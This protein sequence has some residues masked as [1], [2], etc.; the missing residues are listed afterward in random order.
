MTLNEGSHYPELVERIE[1]RVS[2]LLEQS[3]PL[4]RRHRVAVPEPVCLFD[5][6]GRCAG[7]ARA[8]PGMPPQLRFN[9]AMAAVQP[10]RYLDETVPHEVAHLVAAACFG[11][12]I[13]PH[14]EHWR[15]VMRHFGIRDPRRCHD[16]EVVESQVRRQRRWTYDCGC[17][18]HE[19]TTTRH[20]RVRAGRA[21]YVC[22]DCGLTLQ[23]R[24]RENLPEL[25]AGHSGEQ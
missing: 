4:C 3:A 10:R 25:L 1:Q 9:L 2:M 15:S 23:P 13:P 19:L 16:Y 12:N 6:R 5:L 11:R 7:Q 17:R 14:G 20:N 22:R 24:Q 21:R 18:S 8:N